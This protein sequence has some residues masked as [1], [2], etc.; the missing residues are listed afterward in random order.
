MSRGYSILCVDRQPMKSVLSKSAL[1]YEHNSIL[2]FQNKLKKIISS[3]KTQNYLSRTVFKRSKNFR[4][5]SVASE[6]YKFLIKIS[7]KYEK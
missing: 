7:K 1:F 2:N 3:K 5:K 6:T 4:D